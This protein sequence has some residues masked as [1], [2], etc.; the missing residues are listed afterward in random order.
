MVRAQ[1]ESDK[2]NLENAAKLAKRE[3]EQL[4]TQS[5]GQDQFADSFRRMNAEV[6]EANRRMT[7]M[8]ENCSRLER[9]NQALED[10]NKALEDENRALDEGRCLFKGNCE[11]LEKNYSQIRDDYRVSLTVIYAVIPLSKN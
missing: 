7:E 9:K 5:L 2:I 1:S 4:R 3:L 6:I 10:K 11:A 8:R